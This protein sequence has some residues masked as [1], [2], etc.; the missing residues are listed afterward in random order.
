MP[1][2]LIKCRRAVRMYTWKD[3]GQDVYSGMFKDIF[4]DC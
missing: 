4:A 1:I 2:E 3:S